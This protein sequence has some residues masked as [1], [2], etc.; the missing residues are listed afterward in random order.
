MTQLGELK[1]LRLCELTL[2]RLDRGKA[3]EENKCQQVSGS[4]GAPGTTPK[5]PFLVTESALSPDYESPGYQ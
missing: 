1:G 2:I 3:H 4:E 5:C